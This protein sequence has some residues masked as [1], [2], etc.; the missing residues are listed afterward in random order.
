LSGIFINYRR[1]DSQDLAGRLFDRLAQRF[2]K[3]RVFRDVDT[4][5]PGARFGEVITERIGACDAMVVL[6]GRDWLS[7]K[8]AQGCRRL[9]LSNDL[10]KAE[11]AEALAQGKLVI[12]VLIEGAVMPARDA[13]PPEIAALADRH[14][15]P[16]SDS[17]F[18]FDVER[19]NAAIGKIIGPLQATSPK[20]E[21]SHHGV[22]WKRLRDP[23][24]QR[25]LA[26]VGTFIF[27]AALVALSL[28]V[29]I[30]K[31]KDVS[32]AVRDELSDASKHPE[33]I[34]RYIATHCKRGEP[35]I[36][37]RFANLPQAANSMVTDGSDPTYISLVQLGAS[38][39]D[40]LAAC[41]SLLA[42]TGWN[43]NVLS[44]TTVANDF[45]PVSNAADVLPLAPGYVSYL[46]LYAK[47][48]S[49]SGR[50]VP[51]GELHGN[52][53]LY[54]IWHSNAP[55]VRALLEAGGD[56]RTRYTIM[57]GWVGE[58]SDV[59]VFDALTEARRIGQPDI[60]ELMRSTYQAK[61]HH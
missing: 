20:P 48:L 27:V 57:G 15:L 51:P 6:V 10:V 53:L 31:V 17:R 34:G 36:A 1:Q 54:A 30:P 59:P 35:E 56:P 7:A 42:N 25:S 55:L 3:A 9:D 40:R 52:A 38:N 49:V 11:I 45:D 22:L 46:K 33:Q 13:L 12:P 21:S 58:T 44:R 47:G 24:A 14:A 50:D 5:D 39:P 23:G 19:L 8:D 32:D 60:V 28:P 16:I 4:I 29:L 26:F 2:G 37:K 18:D 41:V 61:P 43:P